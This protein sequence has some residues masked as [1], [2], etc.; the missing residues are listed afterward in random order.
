MTVHDLV[1]VLFPETMST[2]SRVYTR[3]TLRSVVS[4]A[5]V[6]VAVSHTTANDLNRLLRV[7]ADRIR[8]VWSGVDEVFV[9]GV[10]A[11]PP[12]IAKPYVLFVGTPE[13]RKNLPRLAQAVSLLRSRGFRER[14]VV[15]GGGGWGNMTIPSDGVDLIGPVSD[16]ELAGLYAHA[17]C[18]AL[19]SLYEG[20]GLTVVEAM[21]AGA[22]VVASRAGA[23]PEISGSAA[24]LVDPYDVSSIASG[25]ERAILERES[26]IALGSERVKQ[27]R[28]D[29]TAEAMTEIY[30]AIA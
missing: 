19:P 22:P 13:P 3:A 4:A 25:I 5:D 27:F 23:L 28:W 10:E 2:W 11:R 20:F 26:L 12:Q 18:L 24:V 6:I 14:L 30:R 21:A 15:A 1:P 17:S 16:R 7:S 29:R 9:E 8:V